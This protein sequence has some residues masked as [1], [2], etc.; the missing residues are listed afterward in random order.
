MKRKSPDDDDAIVV[1]GPSSDTFVQQ[2]P[3]DD[4]ADDPNMDPIYVDGV[5]KLNGM[6]WNFVAPMSFGVFNSNQRK[7]SIDKAKQDKI[8]E[9]REV[10]S[11]Y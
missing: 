11:L 5:E 9:R 10:Q 7:E 4:A 2:V 3:L 8:A 6:R 1:G